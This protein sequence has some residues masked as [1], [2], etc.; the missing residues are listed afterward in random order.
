M[1]SSIGK[2]LASNIK[3]GYNHLL[4]CDYLLN[5]NAAKFTFISIHAE[6][7]RKAVGKLKT[8]K[9]FD[10][11]GISSYFLKLAM[12]FIVDSLGYL[13]NTS[14][15]KSQFPDHW[16]IARVS[17]IF[18]DGDKTESLVISQYR[19]YACLQA[20]CKICLEPVVPVSE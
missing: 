20:L 19:C 4:F 14:L 3:G 9:S 16:K 17:Q 11:D 10:D 7:I 1:N 12:S 13:F 8:S 6:Q 5:S 2:D 18:K 15:E